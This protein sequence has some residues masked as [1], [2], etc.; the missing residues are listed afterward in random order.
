MKKV[1]TFV[2]ISLC[3]L[4]SFNASAAVD[5]FIKIDD[6]PG[7]SIDPEHSGEIDVISWSWGVT[8]PTAINRGG[9][10]S[11]SGRAGTGSI[12][13]KKNVDR[14]S[15][16][17]MKSC[18]TGTYYK[19]A[20]LTVR[21]GDGS[22]IE[23]VKVIMKDLIVKR[24]VT[25]SPEEGEDVLTENVTLNFAE[26]KSEYEPQSPDGSSS[27]KIETNWKIEKGEK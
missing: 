11:G 16:A 12:T 13:V 18:S 20:V 27:G 25:N 24:V 2:L 9:K 19:Q 26:I 6:I 5:M 10:R 8:H 4:L 21:K 14:S 7:E 17:I 15:P 22:R 3:V 1:N 23:Y